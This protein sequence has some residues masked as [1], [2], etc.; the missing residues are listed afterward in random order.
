MNTYS[1]SN[2]SIRRLYMLRLVR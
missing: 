1:I 2:V